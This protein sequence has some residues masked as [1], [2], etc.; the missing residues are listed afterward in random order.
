MSASIRSRVYVAAVS[1]YEPGV[2][3]AAVRRGMEHVTPRI[4]KNLLLHSDWSGGEAEITPA[5]STRPELVSGALNVLLG[6]NRDRLA[7]LGGRGGLEIPARRAL[8]RATGDGVFARQGFARLSRVFG[9]RVRLQPGDEG[10]LYRYQLSVGAL[11]SNE[12]RRDRARVLPPEERASQ[13]VVAGWELYHADTF[14]LLPKLRYSV[15]L[16]GLSGAIALLGH[17][18]QRPE[19]RDLGGDRIRHHRLADLLEIGDPDLVVS[20]GIEVGW[21]G[22]SVCQ[23]GRPLGVV[24]VA[25]NAVAHDAVACRL[26]GLDPEAMPHLVTASSRGYGPLQNDSIDL[27]SEVDFPETALRVRGYGAP[28]LQT[29]VHFRSWYQERT[30]FALGL[31]VLGGES[32]EVAGR[33]RLLAWLMACWDHPDT[34]ERMKDWPEISFMVGVN[35]EGPRYLRVALLGDRA[36]AD[37]SRHCAAERTALAVPR[38]LRR[39]CGGITR[40]VH[41]RRRDGRSGLALAIPGAPP[42]LRDISVGLRLFSLGSIVSPLLRVEGAVSRLFYRLLA[43]FRRRRRNSRGIAVVH[44]RKIERLSDRPWRRLWSSPARLQL[45]EGVQVEALVAPENG[46][47]S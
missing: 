18:L 25:N 9:S 32:S 16:G 6:S 2:V 10:R 7:M 3:E 33:A 24:I 11:L 36:I 8:R 4:G 13:R 28:P 1:V 40:V 31:E 23:S 27:Q 19:D 29:P 42:S 41:F 34:R 12:Q 14:V 45:R 39:L 15:E 44:A 20:D 21:G 43:F 5:A 22:G 30:G 37:F 38:R 17:S 26:L 46:E 47:F 35:D